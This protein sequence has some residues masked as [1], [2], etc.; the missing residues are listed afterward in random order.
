MVDP[1]RSG[2]KRYIGF[3]VDMEQ[4][5]LPDRTQMVVALDRAVDQVGLPKKKRLTLFT[6]ALG[7]ARCDHREQADMVGALQAIH[8]VGGRGATVRTLVTSG[9]IKKV[10]AHLGL[11]RD[12]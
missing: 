12:S 3:R 11:D 5:P 4:G 7:I 6:G 9:T 10:K 2:R 8:E 1:R